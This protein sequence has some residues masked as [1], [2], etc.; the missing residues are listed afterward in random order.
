MKIILTKDVD[1]LGIEGDIIE[2]KNGYA[3]NY[4]LPQGFAVIAT[5]GNLKTWE[6]EKIARD[7]RIAKATEDAKKQAESLAAVKYEIKVKVGEEGKL[8]GAVTAQDIAN[9]V[10]EASKI[11]IDRKKLVIAEPI[12]SV[13]EFAVTVKLY[14]DVKAELTV[15]VSAEEAEA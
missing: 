9:V 2:V 13:G 11:E 10:T 12:K 15:V 8:F 6:N 14:K 1:A 7:R 5:A 3:R 4:L